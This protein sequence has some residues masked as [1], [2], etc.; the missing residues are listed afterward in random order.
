MGGH[1]E[2]K[3]GSRQHVVIEKWYNRSYDNKTAQEYRWQNRDKQNLGNSK[4]HKYKHKQ[5]NQQQ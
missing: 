5:H 3:E 4:E 2:K 1:L